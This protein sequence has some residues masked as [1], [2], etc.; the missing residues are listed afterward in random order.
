MHFNINHTTKGNKRGIVEEKQV[1]NQK[2][3][4]KKKEDWS[5]DLDETVVEL[6]NSFKNANV[7]LAE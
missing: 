7:S 5:K 6:D 2:Y 4:M 1:V 3:L